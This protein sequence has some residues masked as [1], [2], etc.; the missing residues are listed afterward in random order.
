M[1]CAYAPLTLS[2]PPSP[3]PCGKKRG[4][5]RVEEE[6]E[7]PTE[8]DGKSAEP[9]SIDRPTG[10]PTDWRLDLREEAWGKKGSSC[11][12]PFW[13]E[14]EKRNTERTMAFATI[15]GPRKRR[16]GL[17]GRTFGNQKNDSQRRRRGGAL[18]YC[19]ITLP[20]GYSCP[21]FFRLLPLLFFCTLRSEFH[22]VRG[23]RKPAPTGSSY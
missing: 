3:F 10:R 13:Q 19:S 18:Y 22:K 5:K 21:S 9:R 6:E 4:R 17:H 14:R 7:G 20:G 15:D 8:P 1:H 23:T 11:V 12:H 16:I 2:S